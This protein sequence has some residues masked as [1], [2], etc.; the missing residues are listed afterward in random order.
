MINIKDLFTNKNNGK[1]MPYV[2][3][4]LIAVNII[5]FLIE[6]FSGG[7]E[8]VE[9]SLR[10][11][12]FFTPYVI[13]YGQ[14]YRIFTSMFLHFGVEHVGANMI[15][16]YALGPYVEHYFGHAL[17]IVLYIFSGIC[18]N[19]A[20]ML[21]EG[22]TGNITVSCGASG[23]IFGL[24]SVFI[25]FAFNE[26]LRKIFP[27]RRVFLAVLLSLTSGLT[28]PSIN[29]MAHFGGFM[30]GLVLSFLMQEIIRYNVKRRKKSS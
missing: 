30:G 21:Y 20:T 24:L 8:N 7:S 10:F 27:V 4:I 6:E 9:T 2:T 12:A 13:V 22:M 1:W 16:L 28:D 26:R 23:A 5:I 18:G 29:F 25:L 3:Y 11:G 15:T 19:F 17:F 14:L